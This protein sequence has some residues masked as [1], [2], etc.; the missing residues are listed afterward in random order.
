VVLLNYRRRLQP[1]VIL[2]CLGSP[3][4]VAIWYS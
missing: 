4:L 1:S 2:K 3:I